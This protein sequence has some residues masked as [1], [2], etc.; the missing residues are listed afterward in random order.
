M[1]LG[2]C[3]DFGRAKWLVQEVYLNEELNAKPREKFL[4]ILFILI[5]PYLLLNNSP[6]NAAAEIC[7]KPP[8]NIV[9]TA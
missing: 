1:T 9:S 5:P 6:P 7:Q 4:I 3:T 8:L 2:V